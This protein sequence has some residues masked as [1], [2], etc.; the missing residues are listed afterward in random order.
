MSETAVKKLLNKEVVIYTH[1]HLSFLGKLRSVDKGYYVLENLAVYDR[2]IIR[3]SLEE[4][5]IEAQQ[6][7][8]T[9]S[10]KRML[11]PVSNVI[12]LTAL[13]DLI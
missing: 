5:V 8:I 12:C 3:V 11:I 7:G 6:N 10:A 4:Y 13:D 2:E 1:S 9:V